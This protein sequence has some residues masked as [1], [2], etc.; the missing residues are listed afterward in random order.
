MVAP[1]ANMDKT[2]YERMLA[3][4]LDVGKGLLANGASVSRVE[5]AVERICHAYGVQEAN[6]WVV[7]SM[8]IVS[9]V[10]PQG[11]SF[12]LMERVYAIQNNLLNMERYNQLSRDICSK[13][14]TVEFAERALAALKKQRPYHWLWSVGAGSLAAAAFAVLFGGT[15]IDAAITAVIGAVMLLCNNALSIKSFN[16]Y[17]RSFILSFLGGIF[18]ILL[19]AA[20]D[21]LGIECHC[22]MVMIGSIML[23]APGL[24]VCNAVR[25]LFV[26]DLFSGTFQILNGILTMLAIVAGYAAS[27]I[28]LKGIAVYN[29]PIA[30]AGFTYYLYAVLAAIV[31]S[32]GFAITFQTS[33][34]RLGWALL[35]T[36]ATFCVYLLLKN[37]IVDEFIPNLVAT[38]LAAV[39]A[40][41]LA[42]FTKA[43]STVYIIPA[44]IVLVPGGALYY[45]LS[46]LM[47]GDM[48]QFAVWGNKTVQIFL[49]IAV[50]LS[51]VSAIFQLIYPI[52]HK[53]R[54]SLRRFAKNRDKE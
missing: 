2:E 7:P 49:G 48:A 6:V 11:E 9:I 45:T 10:S 41:L 33:F 38:V 53:K 36:V 8:I 52:K 19:T 28:L 25:D 34:K 51:L 13:H 46:Y 39:V 22:S 44:L 18:S 1:S 23:V 54:F 3:V 30:R 12:T 5:N 47:Q 20:A 21:A 42:R 26:G 32:A 16:G 37:F 40:E 14:L 35:C 50:G 43:P 29:D 27:M 15:L 24:M 4:A 31:A 17:A